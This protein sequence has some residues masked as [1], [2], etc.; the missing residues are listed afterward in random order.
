MG[1][2]QILGTAKPHDTRQPA[3]E[4]G[5]P[6]YAELA[7]CADDGDGMMLLFHGP[8]DVERLITALT[9]I[10]TAILQRSAK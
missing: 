7:Q 10:K 4:K 9:S 2:L 8:E 1:M 6:R 5:Q 3:A